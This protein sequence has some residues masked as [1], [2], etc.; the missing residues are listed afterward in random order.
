GKIHDALQK[1][2]QM[3]RGA[4]AAPESA[5]LESAAPRAPKPKPDWR[6]RFKLGRPAVRV[7]G[8]IASVGESTLS[9]EYRTLRARIQSLRRTRELRSIVITSTRPSEGKTTTSANLALSFGLEREGATCLVDADLRTPRLHQIFPGAGP[10]GLA[11]V[12]EGDAKLDEA[13][14]AVPDTRLMVLPVRAL[15]TAPSEL[16]ASRAMADLVTELHT[17]FHTVIFDAPPVLGLPDTVTLVDLCDG[18]L[19]VVGAGR[20]PRDEVESALE[21]LDASK[22]LGVVL[23]RCDDSEVPYASAYG[24]ANR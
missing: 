21:R 11:E 5:P 4:S 22:V 18:S 17:R 6:A 20:A 12:L 9:E 2:E 10:V 8:G 13:L 14:I 7:R 3:R 15:P 1:A 16:L 19:F 24:Y 23:N